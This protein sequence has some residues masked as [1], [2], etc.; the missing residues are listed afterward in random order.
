M[1]IIQKLIHRYMSNEHFYCVIMAGGIG[2]RFWPISR[3]ERPKQF[4]RLSPDGKSF[5]RNTY[6]RMKAIVPEK[7]ILVV[8][9]ERYRSL[10]KNDL[11][12][13]NDEN[14]LME[15]YNRNTAPCL[16]FA[17]Y[18]LLK[19]DP[20]AIVVATPAD[21][22]IEDVPAFNETLN[23]A[24]SYA[25]GA[26]ALITIGVKPTRPD[27]NFGYIQAAGVLEKNRPVR[28]K[29]FT[30]K[31][32]KALAQVFIETGEFLWNSGIFVWRASEIKEEMETYCPE[33]TRL[34][35]GWKDFLGTENQK[36]FLERIYP[37]MPRT[38]IDYSIMEKT[39]NAWVYPATFKWA[40]IGNWES[41]YEY[42][43][44]K[45]ESDNS[46]RIFGKSMLKNCHGNVIFSNDNKKMI[47]IRGMEGFLIID[48]K[49]VLLICPRKDDQLSEFL[50]ELA[51]PE[52][53]EFR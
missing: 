10:V 33:I 39:D 50:S 24:L 21:H 15:P 14:I 32:D 44:S 27:S 31:P 17:T 49:D 3:I 16:A 37:D 23:T 45:D 35:K 34:W 48:M 7:N 29:T 8:T 40:D 1:N 6:D 41:L 12:E 51:L 22:S 52:Y 25:A 9:L 30:E 36:S 38:S 28:V 53:E 11:P 13:I 20:L 4:L 42:L 5:L 26:D 19:H 18:Y 2:S 43:S 46:Y 47:A